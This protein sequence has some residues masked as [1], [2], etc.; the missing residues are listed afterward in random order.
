MY[1]CPRANSVSADRF[2][3]N[4]E[5]KRVYAIIQDGGKQYKVAEGETLTLEKK[6]AEKGTE[7]TLDNVVL[8]STG[9]EVKIGNPVV[10]GASVIAEVLGEAK[11]EKKFIRHYRSRKGSTTRT[12]HR[13]KYIRV[14]VKKINA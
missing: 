3:V 10:A 8:L 11:G 9:D 6:Q 12:G 2:V 5:E 7:I 13:Q 14:K 1:W 4:E